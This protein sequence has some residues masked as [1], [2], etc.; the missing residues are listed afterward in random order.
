MNRDVAVATGLVLLLAVASCS[1][2]TRTTDVPARPQAMTLAGCEMYPE[3]CNG[4]SG[5]PSPEA[6]GYWMGTTVTPDL[7]F[8]P[9][10]A[11]ISDI[12][13]DGMSDNC[14]WLLSDT[15]R[16]SLVS[17]QYDM[18]TGKE[19]Y[20]AAKY[21]PSNGVVRIAYLFSY[22]QDSGAPSSTWG[23][24]ACTIAPDEGMAMWVSA[25]ATAPSWWTVIS[26]L[27]G[28]GGFALASTD[29]ACASHRGDSE[30]V[31]ADV[32][33]DDETQHWYTQRVFMSAHWKATLFDN[34]DWYTT[35]QLE[36][37]EAYGGYPRVWASEGKHANYPSRHH[38]SVHGAPGDTC[39]G[40]SLSTEARLRSSDWNNLGSIQH[41]LLNCVSGGALVNIYPEI[42]SQE[43]YW[44][45]NTRFEG[46]QPYRLNT[47]NGTS[48]AYLWVLL[49]KFECYAY[50]N[51][52]SYDGC[53]D[54]GVD[55]SNS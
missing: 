51:E 54:W 2:L 26:G 22:Y 16:P 6:P 55:R 10:G 49:K 46:W 5:D 12:D 35:S 48:T 37:P 43:C 23:G 7:C 50:S 13:L 19:P 31:M 38:C 45:P 32:V 33:Y 4:N 34:S 20:W 24:M 53:S 42:Y 15:F 44:E 29:E 52:D 47:E 17:S 40:N 25:F 18:D 28:A 30:F 27:L 9:S 1:E 11:G 41:H 3:L 36:F 14:E 39:G 8:S 21:F